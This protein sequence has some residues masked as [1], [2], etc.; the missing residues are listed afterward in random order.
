MNAYKIVATIVLILLWESISGAT[1]HGNDGYVPV[2]NFGIS[3]Y[4]GDAQ[5][6]GCI[7]DA[8]GRLYAANGYGMLCY[9]GAEWHLYHLPNYTSVRSLLYD[10]DADRIYAGGSGEFGFFSSDTSD[11]VPRYTSLSA[12]LSELHPSLTEIWRIIKADGKIWFQGDYH[13]FSY[14]HGILKSYHTNNRISHSAEIGGLIFIALDDG[15]ILRVTGNRIERL[16]GLEQLSGLKI[17]AML[18]FDNGSKMLIGTSLNG[19][20]LYDGVGAVPFECDINR[21][22]KS[23][24]LFCAS[25]SNDNYVFGTVNKGA[26]VKNFKTGQIDYINKES[27]LL[28]NTVLAADFDYAGNIWL[29]LD[30]GL[31]YAVYNTAKRNITGISSPIGAGYAALIMDSQIYLGT[32]QGLFRSRYPMGSAPS[33]EKFEQLL[34]GQVWTMTQDGATIF[35]STDAGAYVSENNG[36]FVKIPGI[37]GTTRIRPLKGSADRALAST[38]HGFHLLGRDN[39]QWKDL[40]RVDGYDDISGDFI[41]DRYGDVWLAH[42]RKGV[43]RLRYNQTTSEFDHCRLFNRESGLREDQNTS[44]ELHDGHAV[45]STSNGFY[46]FNAMNEKMLPN[47]QL[48]SIFGKEL[49]GSFR[50]LN[51]SVM[52]VID[53]H[54]VSIA[55]REH[56]GNYRTDTVTFRNIVDKLI[57]RYTALCFTPDNKL[58]LSGYEGFWSIDTNHPDATRHNPK[59]FVSSVYSAGDSL[60]YRGAGS[61]DSHP[62]TLTVPYSMNSLRFVFGCSEFGSDKEVK[63][64]SWLEG[65][66]DEPSAFSTENTREYTKLPDGEYRLHLKSHNQFNGKVKETV[67]TLKVLPPWYRTTLAKVIWLV[68][69]GLMAWGIYVIVA[70]RIAMSRAAIERKKE[71]EYVALQ[72]KAHHDSMVKDMEI[73]TLRSEKLEQDIRHKS[74]ELSDTTRN[75]IQ[76]NEILQDISAKLKHV[77]EL[78]STDLGRPTAQRI[79]SKIQQVIDDNLSHENDW[80]S[81]SGNFDIVYANF[82]KRLAELHPNL[83]VS[84][85]RLCCYIRMGLQ[86]KDIAPLINISYKSVEMA[87]YR[88]R[89]KLGLAAGDSLTAYLDS[90]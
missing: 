82:T 27:G 59:P 14:G 79:L 90:L 65:Y 46:S 18:P 8:I 71:E 60:L 89:K 80:A 69:A 83:S 37:V 41:Q 78:S 84:D 52:A 45:V 61:P 4:S 7:Q 29:S 44:V 24:Q 87:R 9:D 47:S 11:G 48:A 35:A 77:R 88:V 74:Q 16:K 3:D 5:N 58:L 76:K 54:G 15:S 67:L 34:Q 62:A 32:N 19:L 25:A 57:P 36:K 50:Q 10:D 72:M 23:N 51:D 2:R 38:Y 26:V 70:R 49:R 21:F 56:N 17:T 86:S 6:W 43:Y 42:W 81:F 73:A 33:P 22:L 31:G 1:T 30:Y 28:N 13:F 75:L 12:S 55:I 66:D 64:S 68:M 85:K 53:S 40:G 63:Y 20:Y 39:G